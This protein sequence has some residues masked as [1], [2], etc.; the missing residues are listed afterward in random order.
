[1]KRRTEQELE[2]TLS[3]ISGG[4][5][6]DVATGRGEFIGF[7]QHL[8]KDYN[9]ITGIDSSEKSIKWSTEKNEERT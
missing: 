3:R 8:L 9:S 5:I 1:M 6:L 2:Q 4:N 7:L